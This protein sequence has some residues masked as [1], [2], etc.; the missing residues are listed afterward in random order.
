MSL[1][2]SRG[3][4]YPWVT[5]T[6][7]HL[8]GECPHKCSYCYAQDMERKYKAGHWAGPLRLDEP[9]FSVKYGAGKTIFIEH[10]NDLL[11][12]GVPDE[13]VN[14]ILNHC[15][16]WP[17][18]TYVFQSKNPGRFLDYTW[19]VN[20]ILGTTIETNRTIPGISNA[21]APA[22]RAM[23]MM[24]MFPAVRKFITIEPVLDFDVD[25]LASWIATIR[26]EFLNLGADSKGHGLP[27]PTVEKIM[28][29]VEALKRDGVEL[30]EKHNL[31]RLVQRKD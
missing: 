16:A 21:P 29:L 3:N 26:P 18:N 2:K 9:S 30:R 4:M 7:S 20:S 27:E 12:V 28:Q 1:T 31:A 23:A 15:C 19:P 14:R 13:W 24:H 17:E 5:H 25:V 8:R 11:A 6:H 10:T 22:T